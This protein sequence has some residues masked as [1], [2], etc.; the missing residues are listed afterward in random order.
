[1]IRNKNYKNKS[2]FKVSLLYLQ[3]KMKIWNP[4]KAKKG[5]IHYYIFEFLENLI[6]KN[7]NPKRKERS[8]RKSI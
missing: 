1:M 3:R 6:W 2:N 8:N 4:V 5:F 7:K